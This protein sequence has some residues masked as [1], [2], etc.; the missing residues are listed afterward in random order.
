MAR[1]STIDITG[2]DG[3]RFSA[4]LA[5]PAQGS[6]PGLVLVHEILGLND[7]MRDMA[8]RLAEEGYVCLVPDLYARLETGVDLGYSEV[9]VGRAQALRARFD[10]E[11]GLRDIAATAEALRARTE[12]CGK[13]GIIGWSMGGLLATLAA[14]RLDFACAVSYYGVGLEGHGAEL[15]QLR[16]PVLLQLGDADAKIPAAA[17]EA[18]TGAL[19]AQAHT[20]LHLYPG[21]G[22]GFANPAHGNYDKP[23]AMMAYSRTVALLRRELGPLFDLSRLWDAHTF[24]EFATRDVDATMATMVEQPYVNHIPTMT[25]GVGHDHLKRFYKYHFVNSNPPDTRLIP[26]SRTVGADRL[27]DEMVFCFTHTCEIPW[28]LPGIAP[29]GRYVEIPL[30]AIVNFRGDKLYHEHIYWDQAS[31]LVQIGALDPQGLPVAGIAT[32]KKLIDETLPSNGLMA[33]GWAK[34]EGLPL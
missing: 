14:A 2:A 10:V 18:L 6:G 17:R 33:E 26:V 13:L 19:A 34:S 21:C 31:V 25:G 20:E 24:H 4:Y 27:V 9:D 3:A 15:A 12:Q 1:G 11:Q 7:F 30:V 16:C 28:M 29:S 32:A 8:D 22:H 23:A 5:R